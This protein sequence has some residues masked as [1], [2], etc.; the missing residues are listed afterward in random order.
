LNRKL[1]SVEFT[2]RAKTMS[3][4][5]HLIPVLRKKANSSSA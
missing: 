3:L 4:Q 2:G 5:E 1:G